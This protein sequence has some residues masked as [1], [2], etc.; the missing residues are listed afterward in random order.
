MKKHIALTLTAALLAF[1]V[2]PSLVMAD[3]TSTG[4]TSVTSTMTQPSDASTT[5]Q[6]TSTST[7]ETM[8][9]ETPSTDTDAAAMTEDPAVTTNGEAEVTTASTEEMTV[10][11]LN[12]ETVDPGVL[13]DSPLYWFQALIEK[14]QVALTFDQVEKA[15]VVEQ[16]ALENLAEADALIENGDTVEAEETLI[17]YSE[18]IE[19]AQAFLDELEDPNSET[20]QE[21][22]V[23]LTQVNTNNMVVLGGLLEK[24]PQQA[25]QKIALNIV[26]LMEKAV[27]KA[28]KMESENLTSEDEAETSTVDTDTEV[29]DPADTDDQTK[30]KKQ[31]KQAL[32]QFQVGLG[33]KKAEHTPNGNAYG[34]YQNKPNHEESQDL[35][36][37][38]EQK[39][40]SNLTQNQ[41]ETQINAATSDLKDQ[42]NQNK[43]NK[44]DKATK[45]KGNNN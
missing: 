28:E 22:Q 29:N 7:T 9:I 5:N 17:V 13:P 19:K 20:A 43:N 10:V 45:D 24:L 44:A 1:P 8:G 3:T 34:Y 23:A 26:R 27:A 4:T 21:L 11:G 42:A 38:E 36:V 2:A 14:I 39:E 16:Q 25:A 32:E 6:T 37:E 30:L 31:A 41:Q 12:G 33:L 18:K 15:E 35:E 40:D